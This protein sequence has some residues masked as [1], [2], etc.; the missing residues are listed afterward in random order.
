MTLSLTSI[1]VFATEIFHPAIPTVPGGGNH[2][3][4]FAVS[5]GTQEAHD[6][7]LKVAKA[8]SLVGFRVIDDDVFFGQVRPVIL[9]RKLSLIS[10][11]RL[12]RHLTRPSVEWA[13]ASSYGQTMECDDR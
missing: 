4:E 7:T 12:R 5:A 3:A 8:L 10:A 9:E 2:T 11:R 1:V 13:L 6:E